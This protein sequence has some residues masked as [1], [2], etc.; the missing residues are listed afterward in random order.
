MPGR[1]RVLRYSFLAG[2]LYFGAI[3]LVHLFGIKVPGLFIYFTVPSHQ[4]QD[5]II[6]FLA[7]G[8]ALFFYRGFR[9]PANGGAITLA[10]G[11]ALLGLA[12]IN[13]S[14]DFAQLDAAVTTAPFW[15]QWG[16]LCG[17]VAWLAFWNRQRGSAVGAD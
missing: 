13:L 12:N 2:A 1:H 9:D 17:Y 14:T 8:W 5:S 3:A 10:A 6:S 15:L 16:G 11:V 4:Y 7:F